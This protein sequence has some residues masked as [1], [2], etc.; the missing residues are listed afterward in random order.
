MAKKSNLLLIPFN[1]PHYLKQVLQGWKASDFNEVFCFID[2]ARN[3]LDAEGIAG[4]KAVLKKHGVTQINAQEHNL[5]INKAFESAITW[6]F[7]QVEE[8][9]ILEEDC[10]PDPSF[11]TFSSAMFERYRHDQRVAMLTGSNSHPSNRNSY[12]FSHHFGIWGWGTWRDRWQNYRRITKQQDL[13]KLSFAKLCHFSGS[14]AGGLHLLT[15]FRRQLNPKMGFWDINW[16][17]TNTLL[18]KLCIIPERNLITNIGHFGNSSHK[19]TRFHDLETKSLDIKKLIHPGE[20][21][22]DL[23]RDRY[24]DWQDNFL[25]AL[26]TFTYQTLHSSK[27]V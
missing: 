25:P 12:Y 24:A 7:E 9:V 23:N 1:R 2:G 26:K 5:G 3:E 19:Q 18:D 17:Y 8:G 11:F 20:I 14:L 21:A 15:K 27:F 22:A 13:K 16:A 4:V 10:I 6:F